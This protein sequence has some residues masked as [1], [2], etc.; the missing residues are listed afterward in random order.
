[1]KKCYD[2]RIKRLQLEPGTLAWYY[3]PRRKRG[4]YQKWRRLSTVCL[5]ERRFNDVLY[6]VRLVPRARSITGCVDRLRP[7]EGQP[8]SM[9]RN[10]IDNCGETSSAGEKP[11]AGLMP[12]AK[13]AKVECDARRGETPSASQQP[14]VGPAGVTEIAAHGGH[15][16][17]IHRGSVV[18]S[19]SRRDRRLSWQNTGPEPIHTVY[20]PAKFCGS[21][22]VLRASIQ[23][24]GRL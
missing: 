10:V 5:V 4:R 12:P 22:N 2:A 11:S 1:M 20:D 17:L 3:L 16:P 15:L 7:F 21:R 6:D 19:S 13:R 24:P 9:L 14:S 23:Q 8:P 18:V